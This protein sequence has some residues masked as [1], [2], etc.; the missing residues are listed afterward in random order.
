MG[1]DKYGYEH[2][3]GHY[4]KMTGKDDRVSYSIYEKK[5]RD[6]S[7]PI[8]ANIN[9]IFIELMGYITFILKFDSYKESYD[10][11]NDILSTIGVWAVKYEKRRDLSFVSPT[12]LSE[13]YK[14]IDDLQTKY[15]C[16]DTMGSESEL[17]DYVV[18]WM[19]RLRVIYKKFLDERNENNVK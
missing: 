18:N 4:S 10:E 14:R 2:D 7:E 15:I 6:D 3:D 19:W 13:I 12:E 9:E 1:K 11:Y 17:S 16:N 5:Q 8:Y